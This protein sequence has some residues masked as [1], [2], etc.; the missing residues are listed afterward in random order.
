MIQVTGSRHRTFTFPA[1]L[2]LAFTY[3]SDLGRILPYL[4]HLFHHIRSCDCNIE[5]KPSALYLFYEIT[6]S[7]EICLCLLCLLGLFIF[8]EHQNSR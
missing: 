5:I 2:P 7:D 3:Y 8:R 1:E 4:P 6:V